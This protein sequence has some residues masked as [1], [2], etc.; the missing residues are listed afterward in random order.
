[1]KR[2]GSQGAISTKEN[3]DVM[4]RSNSLRSNQAAKQ[5][6]GKQKPCGKAP[7]PPQDK[8]KAKQPQ[9]I[10]SKPLD[11]QST[12]APEGHNVIIPAENNETSK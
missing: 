11:H 9:Q 10:Q 3:E 8:V 2:Y 6:D 5:T 12:A 7:P 4:K 1:M